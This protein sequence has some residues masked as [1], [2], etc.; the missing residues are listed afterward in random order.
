MSLA[1]DS[2]QT[3]ETT[4]GADEPT[5]VVERLDEEQDAHVAEPQDGAVEP[6]VAEPL[7]VLS[8]A[9]DELPASDDDMGAQLALKNLER[10]RAEK[11]RKRLI[12]IALGVA[13]VAGATSIALARGMLTPDQ[14]EEEAVLETAV[15]EQRDFQ[16]LISATGT[17]KAG[18]TVVVTPEVAGTVEE[19]RVSEGQQVKA[20][21]VLFT[22]KNDELDKA[23]R[24]AAQDVQSAQQ[25]LSAAQ[26]SVSQAAAARD[27]AWARYN[28]AWAEADAQ[29]S[30]WAYLK[31]NYET[32]HSQWA[33]RKATADALA[34]GAPVDPGAEPADP[35][36]VPPNENDFENY[37]D[38]QSAKADYDTAKRLHDDWQ[39]QESKFLQDTDAYK[40]Y[41]DALVLVGDEPMPAGTEPTYPDA[42]DDVSL[43]AAVD[44]AQQSVNSANLA[45]QKAN[46]AY[47]Q[48]VADAEKRTVKATS[49]GSVVAVGVKVGQAVGGA[50]GGTSD[51][52]ATTPLVQISDVNK[53]SVD[54]E[55]NEIDILR[56]K[57]GQK[58]TVTFSAVNDVEAEAV[59]SEVATQATGTSAG[60]G[61][62]TGIV[63][64]HVGLI[65]DHPDAKL[66]PGMSAS[67]KIH[68]VDVN[69][70]LIVPTQAISQGGT[71]A[72]V[73]VVVDEETMQTE[74][75]PVT[76]GP[77]NATE[78]VVESGL[79]AGE[80]VVIGGAQS[81]Y[82]RG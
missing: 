54:I 49:S 10:R 4:D 72:S 37:A 5:T 27:D 1:N 13:V 30:E 26:T 20:G 50:T 53:M 56:V 18:S 82:G 77:S 24:D 68:A 38:Y 60:E 17:L 73:E 2:L 33:Q 57:T 41:Q 32:L 35:G 28:Q 16:D 65:I 78:T 70:A 45:L 79:A 64:F 52:S 7:S 76:L 47:N 51:G 48:R 31:A 14:P 6:G 81:E 61:G 74:I 34:C 8:G 29:H 22:L 63:T 55:V 75:R 59:V 36:P 44:S 46:D 15:V 43:V 80:T 66:R 12:K 69:D 9:T 39:T 58:A 3:V 19:I 62:G 42:P 67:V 23:I 25:S 40:A 21:D 11:K 71:G